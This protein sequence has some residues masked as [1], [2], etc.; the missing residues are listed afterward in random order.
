[1]HLCYRDV[2]ALYL[3]GIFIE[4]YEI[5]LRS[6]EEGIFYKNGIDVEKACGKMPFYCIVK[7]MPAFY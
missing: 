7:Y 4:I 6:I 1:L 2:G 5:G 3:D